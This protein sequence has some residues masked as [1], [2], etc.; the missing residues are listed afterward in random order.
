MERLLIVLLSWFVRV[1]DD[2]VEKVGGI[3]HSRP[4]VRSVTV[5]PTTQSHRSNL[6]KPALASG[7]KP[8]TVIRGLPFSTHPRQ[9][10]LQ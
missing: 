2:D 5:L 10:S 6:L 1:P 3:V 8:C 9:V 4:N 7:T